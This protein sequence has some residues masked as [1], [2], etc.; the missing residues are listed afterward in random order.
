[1]NEK[2]R[3]ILYV[4]TAIVNDDASS[5][6]E[7]LRSFAHSKGL[8]IVGEFVDEGVSG[9]QRQRPQLTQALKSIRRK[10]CTVLVMRDLARLSRSLADLHHFHEVFKKHQVE[11]V[12]TVDMV[13]NLF[14]E[15]LSQNKTAAN[16]MIE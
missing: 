14:F 2:R 11:L 13:P 10:Q 7:T 9:L 6:L 1:M 15:I 16:A 4:R 8:E 5:Q 3:A 12:T